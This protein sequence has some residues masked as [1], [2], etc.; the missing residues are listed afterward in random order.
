MEQLQTDQPA[1]QPKKH[2]MTYAEWK[3]SNP[4]ITPESE[5]EIAELREGVM[6]LVAQWYRSSQAA[7]RRKARQAKQQREKKTNRHK[8]KRSTQSRHGSSR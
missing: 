7:E 8:S 5:K 2:R 3:Q 4:T 6:E 1:P